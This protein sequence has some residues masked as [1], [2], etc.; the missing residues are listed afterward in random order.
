MNRYNLRKTNISY[1]SKCGNPAALTLCKEHL[2]IDIIGQ[3]LDGTY[4]H[5]QSFIDAFIRASQD[6]VNGQ[7]HE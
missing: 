4:P 7:N 2:T 1:C 5:R 3:V 6:F